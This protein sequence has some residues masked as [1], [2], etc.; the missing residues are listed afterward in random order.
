MLNISE[1]R[2][3][4][5]IKQ[6]DYKSLAY[7]NRLDSGRVFFK[8]NGGSFWNNDVVYVFTMDSEY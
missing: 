7:I 1:N 6:T 5:A 2:V 8:N 3:I 4:N